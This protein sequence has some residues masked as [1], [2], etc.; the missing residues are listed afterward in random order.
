MITCSD[1]I[2]VGLS[3]MRSLSFVT[4]FLNIPKLKKEINLTSNEGN[5][6]TNFILNEPLNV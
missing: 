2:P 4:L 6:H 5:P 1:G 3:H